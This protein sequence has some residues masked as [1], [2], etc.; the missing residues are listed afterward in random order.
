[1]HQIIVV[2]AVLNPVG[3]VINHKNGDKTDNRISNL[4]V[5][6][7]GA[8]TAHAWRTGLASADKQSRGENHGLHKLTEEKVKDIKRHLASGDCTQRSL[9]EK[10]GVVESKIS[11]IKYGMTWRHVKI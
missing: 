6:T 11:D 1:M 2:S 10:Y 5:V 8:N 9:Y 7:Q 3:L 4:E